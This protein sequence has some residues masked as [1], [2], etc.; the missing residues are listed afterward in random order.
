MKLQ[1]WKNKCNFLKVANFCN[2][3]TFQQSVHTQRQYATTATTV[4]TVT[5]ALFFSFAPYVIRLGAS[6]PFQS[7]YIPVTFAIQCR[8]LTLFILV[9]PFQQGRIDLIPLPIWLSVM[10]FKST[11]FSFKFD[12]GASF[13]FIVPPNQVWPQQSETRPLFIWCSQTGT[14]HKHIVWKLDLK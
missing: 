14:W 4:T 13:Y 1:W 2:S 6:A 11:L 7:S 12:P 9:L 10:P 8:A 5:T 3:I